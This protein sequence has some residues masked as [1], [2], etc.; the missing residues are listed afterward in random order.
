MDDDAWMQLA[1]AEADRAA[2]HSDVPVG[3]LVVDQTGREIG[4]GHNRREIDRDATAHAELI[5]IR[6]ACASRGHWRLDGATVYATLEP[7]A[8]C[9]GALVNARIA[10]L[11]YGAHDAKAGAIDSL[12]TLGSDQRL[13]HRFQ[14][15]A[16]VQ[17]EASTRRLQAFFAQLRATG[18][19]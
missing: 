16:G 18:K 2:E 7:C 6:A 15:L 4:R 14:V 5:A 9:A 11:V 3:C 12:F 8:M 1:L 13:N 19:K 10:R 17:A